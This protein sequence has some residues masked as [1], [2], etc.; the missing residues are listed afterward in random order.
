MQIQ[1]HEANYECV[2]RS[3]RKQLIVMKV[4]INSHEW[5]SDSVTEQDMK[6]VFSSSSFL[7]HLRDRIYCLL[8]STR[9]VMNIALLISSFL[10]AFKIA[11][12]SLSCPSRA[13]CFLPLAQCSLTLYVFAFQWQTPRRNHSRSPDVLFIAHSH[14]TNPLSLVS[15]AFFKSNA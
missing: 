10:I 8:T 14:D 4:S 11:S 7:A 6:R 13:A 9:Q 2:S 5:H 3:D 15:H 1:C 12:A